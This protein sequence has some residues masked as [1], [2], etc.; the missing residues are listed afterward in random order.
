ME[1]RNG[2][3]IA[4][5]FVAGGEGGKLLLVLQAQGQHRGTVRKRKMIVDC[6]GPSILNSK[7]L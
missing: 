2:R 4:V 3:K 6:G 1:K 5:V 7:K